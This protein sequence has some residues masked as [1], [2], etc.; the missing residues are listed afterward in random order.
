M[1][2]H[3]EWWSQELNPN[4]L[5]QCLKP[6]LE[7]EGVTTSRNMSIKRWLYSCTCCGLLCLKHFP[8]PHWNFSSFSSTMGTPS[9]LC[10]LKLLFSQ[11][12]TPDH[13]SLIHWYLASESCLGFLLLHSLL[14]IFFFAQ[15]H[16]PHPDAGITDILLQLLSHWPPQL[17]SEMFAFLSEAILE[18]SRLMIITI[19][20]TC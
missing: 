2:G 3:M 14:P 13:P 6:D 11:S 16:H 7:K 20:N 12:P 1:P 15:Y 5:T 10:K 4:H 17:E 9:I 8:S 18:A 19:I